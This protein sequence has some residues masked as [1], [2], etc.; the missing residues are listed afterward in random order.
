MDQQYFVTPSMLC[1]ISA[2]SLAWLIV[3]VLLGQRA[4]V[5]KR[6][7]S[8]RQARP[9]RSS[10]DDGSI[11]IYVGNLSYDTQEN[12]LRKTFQQYGKV[13][14]VRVIMNRFN[15]K[16]K[17]FGFVDMPDP[18]EADAAISA[19][20]NKD[21]SGRKIVVNEAKSSAR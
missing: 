13:T 19:L 5:A 6:K 1:L 20:D 17:G 14:G 16:S 18:K 12:D 15:G 2:F 8:K 10:S 11:E 7:K 4:P 21:V 3:G 9:K